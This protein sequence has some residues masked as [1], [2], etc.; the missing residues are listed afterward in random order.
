MNGTGQG[1]TSYRASEV[2]VLKFAEPGVVYTKSWVVELVLDVAGYSSDSNLVDSVAVEPSCGSG[3]FLEA[4]VGRLSASCQRQ[5]RPLRDCGLW[6]EWGRLPRRGP[7]MGAAGGLLLDPELDMVSLGGG[8]DFVVGNPP[9]VRLEFADQTTMGVYRKRYGT[10]AGRADVY[11]GFYE[12]GL[13]MLSPGGV[14]AF[15]CADRWM[16]NQK[17]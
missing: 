10:M 17:P 3:E 6:M 16:L 15:I 8:V 11:M 4:I 1:D 2:G 7:T 12:R 9:Y 5:G 14:C 13:S